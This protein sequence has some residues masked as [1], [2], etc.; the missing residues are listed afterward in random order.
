MELLI[1][2]AI[3]GILAGIALPS[4]QTHV[5]KANRIDMQ[6]AM[7]EM[8]L[9]AER[10]YARQNTYPANV[11]ATNIE[12]PEDFYDVTLISTTTTFTITAT[13]KA[14]SMQVLDECQTL[15]LNQTGASTPAECW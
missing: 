12:W 1:V 6:L 7:S 9:I 15:T 11:A 13:P 4:Y 14:G 8:S 10:Q 2:I 5:R 3:I